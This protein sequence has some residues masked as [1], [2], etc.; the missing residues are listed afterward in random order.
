MS[1]L[2]H[3][4]LT[5]AVLILLVLALRSLCSERLPKRTFRALWSIALL[6][7]LLPKLPHSPLSLYNM[8]EWLMGR[9]HT[10]G[11]A[12]LRAGEIRGFAVNRLA[13]MQSLPSQPAAK[14]IH[15]LL[16]L[17]V[18]GAALCALW[19]VIGGLRTA[20]R[21]RDGQPVCADYAVRWYAADS[22]RRR[23]RLRESSHIATPLAYGMLRPTILLPE[24]FDAREEEMV[25][26]VLLHEEMHLRRGDLWLK[27]GLV[28]AACLYW[29]SPL[30]WVMLRAANRDI[31][32]ACDEA[33]LAHMGL[34]HRSAY[35]MALIRMEAR[36]SEGQILASGF[37]GSALEARITAIMKAKKTTKTAV[38]AAIV[39]CLCVTAGFAATGD[40]LV[41]S[42]E[43]SV[44]AQ[45][46][47]N[48][49]KETIDID[50]QLQAVIPPAEE[51]ELE[52]ECEPEEEPELEPEEK[53]AYD[54]E[55]EP[56]PE[57]WYWPVPVSNNI[58]GRFG[59]RAHPV[60]GEKMV[61]DHIT[62]AAEKDILAAQDGKV[63]EVF[64]DSYSGNTVVIEHIG[65][66]TMYG[67]LAEVDVRVGQYV[68]GGM[69]IGTAGR[70]GQATGNC[71]A[72]W[73][74]QNGTT[75]DPLQ[76][77]NIEPKFTT[78]K[79]IEPVKH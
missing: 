45:N 64:F 35:A 44:E 4:S 28:L 43:V 11:G 50:A 20:R 66:V 5:G 36:K 42:V 33:V 57:V 17:W 68:E 6:H 79:E 65:Y 47:E 71:L 23:I 54:P 74:S 53:P 27:V 58:T 76:F 38:A 8:G 69:P 12:D 7:L 24:G 13:G 73:V 37:A 32:L 2:L 30:S 14:E 34:Q 19:F 46:A 21:F 67:H 25:A 40:P 31:E 3:R 72:F 52:P 78:G 49:K 29:F 22:A 26:C 56:E 62:I 77:Y 15:W 1:G 51:P 55:A 75:V 10:G 63:M 18:A 59:V 9:L 41:E 70:T 60:T 39:L 16:L 61:Y 48:I